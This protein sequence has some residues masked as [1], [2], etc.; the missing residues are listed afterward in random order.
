MNLEKRRKPVVLEHVLGDTWCIVTG[1]CRIALYMPDRQNAVMIDTG[2]K[3]TDREGLLA[4]LE[5]EDIRIH[6]ILV[7]HFHMDHIGNLRPLKEKYGAHTYM[8]YYASAMLNNPG[9]ARMA[10]FE[11]SF[12][13]VPLV[14]P[15]LSA[16][17]HLIDPNTDDVVV[18]GHRFGVISLPGHAVEN[19]GFVTPDGVAYLSDTILSQ[20][21]LRAVR[22]PYCSQC[23]TDLEAK[24]FCRELNYN[25]YILAHNGVVDSIRELAQENIDNMRQKIQIVEDQCREYIPLERLTANVIAITGSNPDDLHKVLGAKRNVQVI[26]DYL[27]Q[28][29]RIDRR[30]HDGYIEYI[31]IS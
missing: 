29:G 17:D 14:G 8:S 26:V 31:A 11:T 12:M 23:A 3:L 16:T 30:A 15:Y 4:L 13:S 18:C 25:R 19:M 10:T 28:T 27:L 24:A 2:M 6:S 9:M 21:V 20:D 1:S 5:Q 7:S 22:I